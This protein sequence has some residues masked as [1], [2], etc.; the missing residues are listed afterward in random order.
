MISRHIT[1]NGSTYF[2]EAFESL[3]Y[4]TRCVPHLLTDE[5]NRQRVKVA[6]KLIQMFQTCDKKLFANVITGNETCVYYFEYVRK[7][8]GKIRANKHSK[9]LIVF[10]RFLSAR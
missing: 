7:V 5:Q 4:F 10:K 9:R 2:E 6:K 3:K 1:I 8:S